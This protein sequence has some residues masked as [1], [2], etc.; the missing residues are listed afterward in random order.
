MLE[1]HVGGGGV[2]VEVHKCGSDVNVE[3]QLPAVWD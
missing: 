1:L 3:T 2:I